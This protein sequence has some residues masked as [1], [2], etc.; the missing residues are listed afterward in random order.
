MDQPGVFIVCIV[1][2][3]VAHWS[4]RVWNHNLKKWAVHGSPSQVSGWLKSRWLAPRQHILHVSSRTAENCSPVS[5]SIVFD[6]FNSR[7]PV[8]Y[9]SGNPACIHPLSPNCCWQHLSGTNQV[10][11]ESVPMKHELYNWIIKHFFLQFIGFNRVFCIQ[12]DLVTHT[13]GNSQL[14]YSY[15]FVIDRV[16]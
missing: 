11:S 9:P 14:S 5:L 1:N 13:N 10:M 12:Q 8:V 7:R 4:H 2:S 6:R 16:N 15:I 3:W